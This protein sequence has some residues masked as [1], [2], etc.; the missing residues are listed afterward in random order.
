MTNTP[1]VVERDCASVSELWDLLSPA[2]GEFDQ[3][4]RQVIFRRQRESIAR[5]WA[6]SKR[7]IA[8][9]FPAW[10]TLRSVCDSSI[11]N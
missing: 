8:C 4:G 11:A 2:G 3:S 6:C 9:G 10:G 5:R 7:S 1:K